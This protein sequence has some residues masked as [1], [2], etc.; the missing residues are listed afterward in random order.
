MPIG[1]PDWLQPAPLPWASHIAWDRRGI[2]QF[3]ETFDRGITNW[4]RQV[5]AGGAVVEPSPVYALHG[6]Y[7]AL[8]TSGIVAGGYA[9]IVMLRGARDYRRTGLEFSFSVDTTTSQIELYVVIY[10]SGAQHTVGLLL[11]VVNETLS[12]FGTE[13]EWVEIAAFTLGWLNPE[14]FQTCKLVFDTDTHHYVRLLYGELEYDISQQPYLYEGSALGPILWISIT[15]WG[16]L[17][18][19]N[20]VYIDNV[21]VTVSEP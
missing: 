16:I 19:N 9:R 20:D 10:S 6:G 3:R 8:L 11:D 7:S 18:Q 5:S 21:I 2:I 17:A 1:H 4:I 15:N 13:D 12:I 14:M